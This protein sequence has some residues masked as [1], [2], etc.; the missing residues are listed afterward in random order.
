MTNYTFLGFALMLMCGLLSVVQV[1]AGTVRDQASCDQFVSNILP[2]QGS[3]NSGSAALSAIGATSISG[4]INIYTKV[5]AFGCNSITV[6]SASGYNQGDTVLVIQMKGANIDTISN[7]PSFGSIR[8]YNDAG[9]YEFNIIK[10]IS[11]NIIYLK[12]ALLNVY[13]PS[14]L[15][16]LIRV[17][18]Y[19]NVT[20]SGT[21]TAL[22]WNGNTGG[23]L[24]FN[25]A[26]TV[27]LNA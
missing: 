17:P 11:G 24:V 18:Y 15:V 1:E 20:V 6:A 13:D 16:Q 12:N 19:N 5:T 14:G 27:T 25:A 2:N 3:A 7:T 26:G 9:N 23:V 4:V 10:S 8:K 21:L 22:P